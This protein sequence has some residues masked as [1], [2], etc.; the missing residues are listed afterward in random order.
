[1][2]KYQTKVHSHLLYILLYGPPTKKKKTHKKTKPKPQK[3]KHRGEQKKN[4]SSMLGEK[5]KSQV[6]AARK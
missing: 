6:G 2:R 3:N 5:K 1:M 4:L